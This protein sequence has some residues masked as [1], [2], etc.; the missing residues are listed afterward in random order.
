MQFSLLATVLL[1]SLASAAAPYKKGK[2]VKSWVTG[3]CYKDSSFSDFEPTTFTAGNI[4]GQD[5]WKKTGSFNVNVVTTTVH[6]FGKQ[7]LLIKDTVTSGSFGDQTFA[8]PLKASVGEHDATLSTFTETHRYKH[9]ESQFE[10]KSASTTLQPGMHMSVSADRGD[11]SRMTY[12]RFTDAP[13]GI[14]V[15]FDDVQGILPALDGVCAGSGVCANFAERVVATLSR[16]KKHTIGVTLTT[17]EGDSNDVV[18]VYID[19]KLV[20]TGTSWEDYYV[21]DPE[22]S[23]EQSVR[24]TKTLLFRVSGPSHAASVGFLVDNVLIGAY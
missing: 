9:F 22:S 8:K 16:N 12:L 14:K 10:F 1:A 23:A 21:Y 5:G 7:A 11:G 24:V 19:G 18:N 6:G 20:H 17:K 2:C 15:I 4:N 13:D 3:S